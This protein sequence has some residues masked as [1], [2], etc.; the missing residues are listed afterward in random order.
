MHVLVYTVSITFALFCGI[1]CAKYSKQNEERCLGYY[2]KGE[3]FDL[4]TLQGDLNAVYFWPPPQRL[5]DSCEVIT[6]TSLLAN[7]LAIYSAECNNLTVSDQTAVKATYKNSAGKMVNVLYF[8]NEETKNMYRS[9]DRALSK[10]LFLKVNQNYVLGINC[11]AGGRGV[12]LA[13]LLPRKAEVQ[14]VVDGIEIMTG[15]EGNPDCPLA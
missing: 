6:F 3:N 2:K 15:R 4:S 10:Y 9:C 12:L 11:S 7:E 8:G 13:R 14:A 1:D 5:R